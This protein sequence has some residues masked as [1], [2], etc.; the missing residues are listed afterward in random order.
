MRVIDRRK[1]LP[2]TLGILYL[3]AARAQGWSIVGLSFPGHFLLRIDHKGARAIIDPFNDG[4]RHDA[5][6][7][8]GSITRASPIGK[9]SCACGTTSNCA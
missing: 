7:M 4:Q 6:A 2:V 9:S 1:G 5:G 3:H 8:R